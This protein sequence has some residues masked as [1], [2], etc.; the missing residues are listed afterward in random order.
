MMNYNPKEHGREVFPLNLARSH[1]GPLTGR[2]SLIIQSASSHAT[3][4]PLQISEDERMKDNNIID[5]H[6]S[7]SCADLKTGI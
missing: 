2:V 7:I 4:Y 5:S 6:Y 1:F 3:S